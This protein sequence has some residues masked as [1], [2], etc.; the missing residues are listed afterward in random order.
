M[1]VDIILDR[2]PLL[3]PVRDQGARPTCLAHASTTAHEHARGS[4][5][6]LSP[7]YLHYFA[8]GHDSSPEGVDF[9]N[10]SR[11]LLDSGQPAETD[12]PYHQDNPPPAWVPPTNVLL[13]RRHTSSPKQS[14]DEVEAL[15]DAG[16][17]PVL[18]ISTTDAFYTPAPPWVISSTG[19]VR[20]LHAVV[21]VGIGTTYSTRRFLIR[22]SWGA[23]W[24]DAGHAW[25]DDVFIVQHLRDVLVLTEEA[26]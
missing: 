15:L 22:N 14:P 5:V 24:A 16:H 13:Y 10:V 20:G 11:T 12:C 9:P 7:E 1:S 6:A 21:A 19:P 17:V 25:L 18:G 4:T 2:R 8:S 3:G 23:A 26:T